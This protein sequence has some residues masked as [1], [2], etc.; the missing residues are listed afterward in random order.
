MVI[1][2]WQSVLLLIAC[3]MM[4]LFSFCQLGWIDGASLRVNI[5]SFGMY[6][7]ESGKTLMSTWYITVVAALSALLALMAIFMFKNT[8]LQKR[9]SMFSLVLS[10]AAL[11]SEYLVATAL[12]VPG[13]TAG[14]HYSTMAFGPFVAV[15]AL[16]LAYRCIR[17]D[18]RKLSS[19]DRL[20]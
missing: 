8:R 9:V 7:E 1:Q 20:R 10:L 6:A 16:L 13:D 4:A 11:G 19:M 18:E 5:Y 15:A 3:V 14:I 17:S 2:R 12:Q